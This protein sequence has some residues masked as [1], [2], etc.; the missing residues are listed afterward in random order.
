[1]KRFLKTLILAVM[2]A[3]L[4][5]VA[6][7]C[8][9]NDGDDEKGLK[10]T[11]YT[12]DEYYTV[13]SYVGDEDVTVLD[14]AKEAE[15]LST[16]K[17]VEVVIGRIKAN[18]FSGNDT[19]KEIIVPSTVEVMDE[20][21]FAGM[22]KLEKLTIPFVGTSVNADSS[23]GQSGKGD[24]AVDSKRTFGALFGTESYDFGTSVKQ[25]YDASNSIST[26]LPISLEEVTI[27]PKDNYELPMYAF[28]GNNLISKVNLTNKVTVIGENAFNG[29]TMLSVITDGTEI[30]LPSS[31]KTIK[32]GAFNGCVNLKDAGFKLNDGLEAIG[33]KAFEGVGLSEVVIPNSVLSIGNRCFKASTV[34]KVTISTAVIADYAFYNCNDLEV[35]ALADTVTT[36][37]DF[38]FAECDSL[39]FIGKEYTEGD[40]GTE[41]GGITLEPNWNYN[42]DI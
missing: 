11:K 4:T 40:T 16:E 32:N 22:R 19:L 12:G 17:G 8:G 13:S 30:G 35:V 20:G 25:N 37:G 28:S 41:L 3:S 15:K 31:V 9:N 18:A 34:K 36:I 21:A 39:I 27:S 10:I 29:C 33:E 24:K 5:I 2:V 26:Y 38:A 7:G 42:T 1:M 6:I 14:L 23:F